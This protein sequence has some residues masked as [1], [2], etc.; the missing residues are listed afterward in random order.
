MLGHQAQWAKETELRELRDEIKKMESEWMRPTVQ[1]E[2]PGEDAKPEDCK[3]E[4]YGGA[5]SHNKLD[6]RKKYITKQ[7][8][9]IEDFNKMDEEAKHFQKEK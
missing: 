6:M 7:L 8:R 5:D 3:M 4:V 9:K 2:E 1:F